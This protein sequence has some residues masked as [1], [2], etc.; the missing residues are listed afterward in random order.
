MRQWRLWLRINSPMGMIM[1][2]KLN[3]QLDQK[4]LAE[5]F[6]KAGRVQIKDAMDAKCADTLSETIE[7]MAIWRSVYMEGDQ[8]RSKHGQEMASM[9]DRRR[10]EMIERAYLQ[11]RDQYQ[12]LRYDCPL[13][14]I[15]N[16][17]DPKAL[18]DADVYFNSDGFRDFLRTVAGS[19]DGELENVHARWLQREQFMTDSALA[20]N[21]PDCKLWFSMDM[22]RTWQP[23]WGGHLNFLDSDG[24]IEEAW[25]PGFNRLNIYA[26]GTRHS[27]SY[28][29]PFHKAFCLSICGRLV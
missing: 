13:D 22:T 3:D 28:V 24:E 10:R 21:L 14:E 1:E 15:P 2:Y 9:T 8:D 5:N 12:Y 18:K 4:A 20:T 6:K 11:A 25:S 16:A 27:I 29:T 19:K 7:K 17:K 26:G 23:H